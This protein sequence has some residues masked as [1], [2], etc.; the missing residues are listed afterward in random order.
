MNRKK[1]EK[2]KRHQFSE[3]Q[4]GTQ[5][6]PSCFLEQVSFDHPSKASSWSRSI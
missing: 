2:K 5:V 3:F 6:L 4:Q 1:E